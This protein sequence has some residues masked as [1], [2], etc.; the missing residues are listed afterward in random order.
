MIAAIGRS[1][2]AAT[3]KPGLKNDL[4][5]DENDSTIAMQEPAPTTA[6]NVDTPATSFKRIDS[7]TPVLPVWILDELR[8]QKRRE[9]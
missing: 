6:D 1:R 7:V 3:S 5:D 9:V 2:E 4:S 8:T